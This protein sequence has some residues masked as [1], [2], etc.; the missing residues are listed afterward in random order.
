MSYSHNL[1]G[2]LA[3]F[4]SFGYTINYSRDSIGRLTA[5]S[6]SPFGGVTQYVSNIK[7]R[8]WGAR[9]EFDLR[10]QPHRVDDTTAGSC[11]PAT[12]RRM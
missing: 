6:V 10:K 1:A 2:Q 8:A 7:Y 12:H 11:R 3:S 9:R 4:N 5:V